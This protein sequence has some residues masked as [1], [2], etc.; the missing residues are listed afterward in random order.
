MRSDD[1]LDRLRELLTQAGVD[2]ERPSA[3]DVQLTWGVIRAFADEPVEDADP[4]EQDGDGILA[5]Y[6]TYDFG[7][8]EHFDLDM[9]RQFS[10][11]D[12]E[13][14]YDHMSQ[15]TCAFRFEPTPE[16]R[17]VGEANLWGFSRPRDEFFEQAL[18]MP[19]FARVRELGVAPYALDLGYSDV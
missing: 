15:L 19:G 4:P 3:A 1:A 7:D 10:F 13:G 9:T 18:A 14:E 12:D 16:L 2:L 5:Q 6:G 8:G 11:S 17:A